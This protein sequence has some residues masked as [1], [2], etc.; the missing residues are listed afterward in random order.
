MI[1]DVREVYSV[2]FIELSNEIHNN[3]YNYT[4][5]KYENTNTK[6]I[7][8]CPKHGDFLQLPASH[9]SGYGCNRCRKVS[10]SKKQIEWLEYLMK[11]ENIFIKHA[12]NGGEITYDINNRRT[13]KNRKKTFTIY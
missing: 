4:K 6:I 1:N 5:S 7:I 8:T 12:L 3:K 9:L 11:K 2:K 13:K 10:Y